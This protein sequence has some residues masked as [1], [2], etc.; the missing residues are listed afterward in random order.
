M[1]VMIN[2]GYLGLIR[3][4]EIKDEMNYAVDNAYDESYGIDH[5]G[6]MEAM[7]GYGRR[8]ERPEEIGPALL[9]A[10]DLAAERR[11]PVLVEVMIEREENAAMGT[12]LDAIVEFQEDDRAAPGVPVTVAV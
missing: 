2:N 1:L 7:G 4:S 8:V 9:W 11:R 5:V 12:A 10:Q 3:Q 6:V